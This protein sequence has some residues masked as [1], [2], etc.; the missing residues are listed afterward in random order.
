ML[1]AVNLAGNKN[2]FCMTILKIDHMCI[3][4]SYITHHAMRS[5][6]YEHGNGGTAQGKVFTNPTQP[7]EFCFVAA[8]IYSA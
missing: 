1:M 6:I 7:N 8:T 5:L 2:K 3:S 4:N